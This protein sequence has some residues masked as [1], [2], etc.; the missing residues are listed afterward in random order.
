MPS[1]STFRDQLLI[2]S[3]GESA[4]RANPVSSVKAIVEIAILALTV[5]EILAELIV[6]KLAQGVADGYMC[7]LHT[8]GHIRRHQQT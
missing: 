8:S 5:I 4:Y 6:D 3:R 1:R 2:A 7:L